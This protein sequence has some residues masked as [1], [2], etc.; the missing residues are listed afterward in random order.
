MN[1]T[2]ICETCDH[3]YPK[4]GCHFMPCNVAWMSDGDGFRWA[5]QWHWVDSCT[6]ACG[7]WKERG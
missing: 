3:Y 1:E 6:T 7:Q 5:E 4:T 2:K